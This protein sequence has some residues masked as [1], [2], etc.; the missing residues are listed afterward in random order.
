MPPFGELLLQP[1]QQDH[2]VRRALLERLLR[3]EREPSNDSRR[4]R[5]TS[6]DL[7]RA[8]LVVKEAAPH[9][10]DEIRFAIKVHRWNSA[11]PRGRPFEQKT[12]TTALAVHFLKRCRQKS[13]E[14][15]VANTL[16]SIGIHI[17]VE[18]VKRDYQR[19]KRSRDL[20]SELLWWLWR[21]CRDILP[22]QALEKANGLSDPRTLGGSTS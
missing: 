17:S 16:S 19:K 10:L 5:F 6:R 20:D 1:P 15:E 9:L 12:L 18:S 3:A 4:S 11:N 2:S 7:Q 13:A 21:T 14:E 22:M 8:E